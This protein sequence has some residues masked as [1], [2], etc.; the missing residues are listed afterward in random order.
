MAAI[1]QKGTTLKIGF[2]SAAYTGFVLQS[3]TREQTGEQKV[4][5]DVNNATMTVLV[6]DLGDR[7]SFSA[8]ILDATGSIV[9]PAVGSTITITNPS[10]VSTVGR[11]ESASV[12]H[13]AEESILNVTLIKE[14]SIT[15]T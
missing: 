8:L 7:Y 11:V 5:K 14:A 15:Y 10:N 4:L 12:Q 9:P 1:V 3:L 13:T 2:G 6:E